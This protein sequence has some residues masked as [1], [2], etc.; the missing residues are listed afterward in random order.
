MKN[1]DVAVFGPEGYAGQELT[2]LLENHPDVGQVVPVGRDSD[3]DLVGIDAAF[4]ALPTNSSAQEAPKL[5]QAGATVIDLSGY[6]RFETAAE[7]KRWYGEEHRSPELLSTA[8]YGLPEFSRDTMA[9]KKLIA[10]PGCYPTATLL[11]LTP[12]T[13]EGL[14]SP[15]GSV[16]VDA[17][18][19]VSGMGIKKVDEAN[20]V[21]GWSDSYAYKVG[22]VHPHVG[23]IEQFLGGEKI[24][25]SP[26]V[27]PFF[28]GM[29]VRT[30]VQLKDGI[31]PEHVQSV[32]EET[33][34]GEPFV[35]VLPM[36]EIPSVETTSCTD[37]C[38]IGIVAAGSTLQIVSSI[39]NLGKGAASQAV[40]GFNVVFELDEATG[41]TPYQLIAN[42]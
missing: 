28:R 14:L 10:N 15:Y 36:G 3:Q 25:F 35:Q 26:S 31:K 37:N 32:L 18:S 11:G 21:M 7:Y 33:Y 39:D 29:L 20:R 23:E 1:L 6:F 38:A 4:L 12:L 30:T 16:V 42:S 40:Q 5:L 9:G 19:G 17:I 24:F 34:D 13:D 41:L 2:K 22:R 27:G 8:V